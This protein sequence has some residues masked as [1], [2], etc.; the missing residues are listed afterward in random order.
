VLARH[1]KLTLDPTNDTDY[2]G[3]PYPFGMDPVSVENFGLL[4][5]VL[6]FSPEHRVSRQVNVN[7]HRPRAL[8]Q[9]L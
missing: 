7:L 4:R 8:P 6:R 5:G 2:Y 1:E 3:S 9:N